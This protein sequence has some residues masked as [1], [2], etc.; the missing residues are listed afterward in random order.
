MRFLMFYTPAPG[1]HAGGPP[2]EAYRNKMNNLVEASRRSGEL[3]ATGGLTPLRDGAQV[4]QSTGKQTV[5]D[6]PFIESTE[7]MGGFALF[8]LPSKEK[9]IESAQEF[10]KIAGDGTVTIRPLMEEPARPQKA[11]DQ[12]AHEE[13]LQ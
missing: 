9:A 6:G 1:A 12:R 3:I 11:Q 13:A 5:T 10:L 4:A 2:S 7:V 8:E